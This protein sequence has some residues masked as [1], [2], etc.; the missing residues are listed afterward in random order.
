[1]RIYILNS[2]NFNDKA[3]ILV[4]QILFRIVYNDAVLLRDYFT[5]IIAWQNL[6][7]NLSDL[8]AQIV[9]DFEVRFGRNQVGKG[10]GKYHSRANLVW[11]VG[12]FVERIVF[13]FSLL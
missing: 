13:L 11:S 3:D 1:M 10:F 12:V 2:I 4:D 9:N 7:I 6:H 5:L 8:L